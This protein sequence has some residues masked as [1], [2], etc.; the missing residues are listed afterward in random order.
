MYPPDHD[1][2]HILRIDAQRALEAERPHSGRVSPAS[3]S[4]LAAN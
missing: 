2:P 3:G 1:K 4:K